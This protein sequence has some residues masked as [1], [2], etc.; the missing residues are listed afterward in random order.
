ME[1]RKGK[2]A[3]SPNPRGEDADQKT[4]ILSTSPRFRALFDRA[5]A[6][7]RTSPDDLPIRAMRL[8]GRSWRRNPE[9]D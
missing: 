4:L 3:P 8:A 7:K 1:S 5:A 2:R 9:R 6:G